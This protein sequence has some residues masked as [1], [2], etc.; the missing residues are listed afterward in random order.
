MLMGGGLLASMSRGAILA[1]VGATLLSLHFLR[2]AGMKIRHVLLALVALG[3]MVALI[4]MDLLQTNVDLFVYRLV[5]PICS[6]E[7]CYYRTMP[8]RKSSTL[9]GRPSRRT[10]FSGWGPESWGMRLI[11]T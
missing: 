9:P 11:T 5:K 3:L 2:R 8:E 6:D 4:P 10:R 7:F 1:I